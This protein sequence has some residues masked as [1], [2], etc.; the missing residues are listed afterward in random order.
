MD[1]AIL[2]IQLAAILY[3]EAVIYL[4]PSLVAITAK[5][6]DQKERIFRFNAYFGWTIVGWIWALIWAIS[7]EKGGNHLHRTE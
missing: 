1:I 2:C 3:M 4:I 7:I 6:K 5:D